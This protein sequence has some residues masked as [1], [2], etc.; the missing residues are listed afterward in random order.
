ML[1]PREP[2]QDTHAPR[3]HQLPQSSIPTQEPKET[4]IQFPTAGN[5]YP[6]LYLPIPENYRISDTFYEYIHSISED[7]NAMVLVELTGLCY[8]Y[9]S[10]MYAVDRVNGTMYGMFDGDF[11]VI[12]KNATQMPK[13]VYT[14]IAR[15]YGPAQAA[16]VSTLEGQIQLVIPM[17]KST[18][19]TQSSQ[20]PMIP[21]GRML[22]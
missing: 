10:T 20:V 4:L 6:Y 14:L 8:R 15:M 9:R 2:R 12:S 1:I 18:P 17:A 13:Y 19:I 11:K 5:A 3:A 16:Q 21:P 22:L 7:N